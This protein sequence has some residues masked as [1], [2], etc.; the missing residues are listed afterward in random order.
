MAEVAKAA[1]HTGARAHRPQLPSQQQQQ[2]QQ[3]QPPNNKKRRRCSAALS[4]LAIE[5]AQ[6]EAALALRAAAV[7]R[8]LLAAQRRWHFNARARAA[9][10]AGGSSSGSCAGGAGASYE[11]RVLRIT[12]RHEVERVGQHMTSE[13][14]W[15]LKLHGRLLPPP[16]VVEAEAACAAAVAEADEAVR[17][18]RGEREPAAVAS[19]WRDAG[20]GGRVAIVMARRPQ[21]PARWTRPGPGGAAP[22]PRVPMSKNLP[23]EELAH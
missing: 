16:A 11:E 23:M 10:A 21:R 13:S 17:V 12:L 4:E 2:Q 3:Q 14:R 1:L 18:A 8:E 20:R 15:T 9:L 7:E 22:G 19:L 5:S 6:E